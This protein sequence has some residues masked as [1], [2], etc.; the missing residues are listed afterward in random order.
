MVIRQTAARVYN[1]AWK[2]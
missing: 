2:N 1:E